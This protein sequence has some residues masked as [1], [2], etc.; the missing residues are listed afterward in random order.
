MAGSGQYDLGTDTKLNLL[1]LMSLNE[2]Y[3]A[4]S[5]AEDVQ[6]FPALQLTNGLRW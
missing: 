3:N 1:Y 5:L 4:L 6:A 2:T